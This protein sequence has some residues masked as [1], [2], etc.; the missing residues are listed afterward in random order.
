MNKK[1]FG[2]FV[3][4]VSILNIYSQ[5]ETIENPSK[6]IIHLMPV[7]APDSVK[8]RNKIDGSG[9]KVGKWQY[10]SEN[11]KL[12][13]SIEYQNNKRDGEYARYQV[14]SGLLFEKGYYKNGIKHG[15]YFRYF[16][17]GSIRVKGLY[18]SGFKSGIWLYYYRD[19]GSLRSKGV[20]TRGR[21][22]G[23]WLFYDKLE[24]VK[25][26]VEYVN[27]EIIKSDNDTILL[28]KLKN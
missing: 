12:I 14:N 2:V 11:G 13:L 7:N 22:D 8:H 25:R 17:D 27:G 3:L 1:I 6:E 10:Y 19:S 28:R 23:I 5:E 26:Q 18:E 15:E 24:A 20:F 9:N 16:T 21:K 4:M